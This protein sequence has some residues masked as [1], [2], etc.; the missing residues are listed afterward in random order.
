MTDSF[1]RVGYSFSRSRSHSMCFI[2]YFIFILLHIPPPFVHH[3]LRLSRPPDVLRSID[4]FPLEKLMD[5]PHF[6]YVANEQR[7]IG[8]QRECKGKKKKTTSTSP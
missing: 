1:V 3:I 8:P 7:P 5:T 2:I 4:S 6:V